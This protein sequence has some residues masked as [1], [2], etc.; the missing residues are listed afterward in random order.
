[1]AGVLNIEIKVS[2]IFLLAIILMQEQYDTYLK[3]A[4]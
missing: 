1:M 3:Y 2:I 4:H